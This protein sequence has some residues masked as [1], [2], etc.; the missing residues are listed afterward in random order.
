MLGEAFA[1]EVEK[2]CVLGGKVNLP[3]N[4]NLLSLFKKFTEKKCDIYFSE[5][6]GLDMSKPKAISDKRTCL[7]KHINAALMSLFS[8]YELKQLLDVKYSRFLEDTSK[9]LQTSEPCDVGMITECKD[10][11]SRFIHRC[12]AEYFAAIWFTRNFTECKEFISHNLFSSTYEVIRNIFD[13]IIAE[14]FELHEA[15]LNNDLNAVNN[16]LKGNNTHINN[17]DR[18]GRTALHLAASYNSTIIKTLL[19]DKSVY[20]NITDGV[21]EWTPLRYAARTRSWMAMDNLLQSGGNP[22]DIVLPSSKIDHQEWVQA[23]LSVSARKGHEKLLEHMLNTGC[24]VNAYLRV[25]R[26]RLTLLHLAILNN[27]YDV[28]RLL[29]EMGAN[30]KKRS[31]YSYTALHFA[32]RADNV[33]IITLLLDNG[34]SVNVTNKW[35]DTP[36]HSAA[37]RGS[38]SATEVLF[39]RGAA[40][41]KTHGG[42]RTALMDAA[43]KGE[44]EVVRFLVENGADVNKSSRSKGSALCQATENGQLELMRYLLDNGADVKAR[45]NR[46][47]RRPLYIATVKQNLQTVKWL[48]EIGADV[49]ISTRPY[50]SHTRSPL[51]VAAQYG[52]LE[53]MDCLMNAGANVNVL[54]SDGVTPLSYAAAE[55]KTEAVFHL[56]ENGADV[57]LCEGRFLKRSALYVAAQNGNLEIMDCLIEAGANLNVLDFNG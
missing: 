50:H 49:N 21:L 36:L 20:T 45:I 22:D 40:I 12:F 23:A 48:I 33:D 38:L 56:V 10:N 42:G 24:D 54:D 41:D 52:N 47:S 18:G 2:Y 8:P 19:S 53:I 37:L 51:H 39:R 57:N 3:Q 5:K 34:M 17:V 15:V 9:F 32:A 6:I 29:I 14:G 27:Q 26:R 35:G 43:W 11:K 25:D 4:F 28:V 31:S 1:K 55:D 7:D 46:R 13:R 16:L 44:M 30:I